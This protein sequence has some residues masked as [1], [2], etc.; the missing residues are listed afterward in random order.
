MLQ[1]KSLG[2]DDL[3]KFPFPTPP[4]PAQLQAAHRKL[5]LL[6]ALDPATHKVDPENFFGSLSLPVWPV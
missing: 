3:Q 2:L 1:M 4:S 6:G 5:A